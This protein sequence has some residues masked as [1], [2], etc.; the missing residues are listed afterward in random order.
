MIKA[1]VENGDDYIVEGCYVLPRHADD[2]RTKYPGQVKACFL[3]YAN[4]SPSD[5]LA[6][7]RRY[8]G[9][10]GDP[11]RDYTDDAAVSNIRRFIS[12]SRFVRD[13]CFRLGFPYLEVRDRDEAVAAATRELLKGEDGEH[14]PEGDIRKAGSEE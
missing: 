14:S 5:K 10:P 4:M 7:V 3:G 6:E 1:M 9:A 8:G 13:E 2:T 11:L 12:Y